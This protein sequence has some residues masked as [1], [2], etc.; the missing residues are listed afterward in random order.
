VNGGRDPAS[1]TPDEVQRLI[2]QRA[3]AMRFLAILVERAGG[4]VTLKPAD[5][6]DHRFLERDD[7]PFTGVVVL[8]SRR[9]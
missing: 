3:D 5:F 7:I 4:E 8:K 2:M 6:R 1:Y 9:V